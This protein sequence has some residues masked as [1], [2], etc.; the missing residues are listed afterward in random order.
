M[1]LAATCRA[2]GDL[3]RCIGLLEQARETAEAKILERPIYAVTL[4]KLADAYRATGRLTESIALYEPLANCG[5]GGP[6]PSTLKTMN[7]LAVAYRFQTAPDAIRLPGNRTQAEVRAPTTRHAHH[8]CQFAD[9]TGRLGSCRYAATLDQGNRYRNRQYRY[10]LARVIIQPQRWPEEAEE[11]E[12]AE[13]R[14]RNWLAFVKQ[15]SGSH[16]SSTAMNF[17]SGMN[18]LQQKNRPVERYCGMPGDLQTARP[19][20]WTTFRMMTF[21]ADSLIDRRGMPM[22]S[23]SWSTPMKA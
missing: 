8:D 5:E 10:E 13:V 21:V 1:E 23:H 15:K 3:P 2:D 7:G 16:P 19:D 12:Q 6:S 20:D 11:W 22:P 18:L 17:I 14:Q 4:N 9:A